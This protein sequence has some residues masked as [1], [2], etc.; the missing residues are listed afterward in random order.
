MKIQTITVSALFAA[1]GVLLWLNM[2]IPDRIAN[3]HNINRTPD[4]I[5]PLTKLLFYRGWPFHPSD[6]CVFGLSNAHPDWKVQLAAFMD[7][8]IFLFALTI[9]GVV[10]E[11]CCRYWSK[12]KVDETMEGKGDGH[13]S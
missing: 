9:T 3:L 8:I 13:N 2:Q 6:Y 11:V 5:D 4:E 7:V 10:F 12:R 1:G